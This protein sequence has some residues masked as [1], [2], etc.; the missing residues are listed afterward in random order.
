MAPNQDWGLPPREPNDIHRQAEARAQ[1]G[2]AEVRAALEQRLRQAAR[3]QA[4]LGSAVR[5]EILVAG[6]WGSA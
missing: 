3:F 4:R 1:P 6:T 5:S 2:Q